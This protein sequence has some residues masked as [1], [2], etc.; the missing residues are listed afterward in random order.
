M[1]ATFSKSDRVSAALR[2]DDVDHVPVSA[3]WHD[4][5]REWS[6]E[7]L[8]QATIEAYRQYDWDFIKVN[9]R[10]TYYAEDWGARF[11]PSGRPDKQPELI[12]PAV[13]AP[14]DLARIQPLDV[15]RGAY[16]EQ[17]AAL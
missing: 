4:F 1:R 17:L 3:W 14:E 15:T 13:R 2:G 11:Q 8:A 9:P 12:E 6:P 7:G 5:L 10:A 16:G